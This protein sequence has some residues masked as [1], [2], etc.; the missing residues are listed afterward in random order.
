MSI[1]FEH[2]EKQDVCWGTTGDF[3]VRCDV[4]HEPITG[5]GNVEMAE[6]ADGTH[7]K[8]WMSHKGDCAF[9]LVHY[10]RE[11]GIWTSWVDIGDM[12]RALA[13]R[14]CRACYDRK[15]VES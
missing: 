15:G 1:N 13:S 14:W 5:E 11:Q 3:V 10:L 9:S 8:M 7:G 6:E 12:F 2:R 4:C